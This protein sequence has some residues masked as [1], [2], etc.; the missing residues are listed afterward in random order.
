MKKSSFFLA[1]V[2]V[3]GAPTTSVM[4]ATTD[5]VPQ[6][7]TVQEINYADLLEMNDVDYFVQKIDEYRG[8]HPKANLD[9]INNYLKQEMNDRYSY[10][11][12]PG[13]LYT[14]E[15]PIPID[16]SQLNQQ[17]KDLYNSNMAYGLLSLSTGALAVN[18]AKRRY[19]NDCLDGGNGDA[20]R[21]AFWNAM[22]V[23]QTSVD[24]ATKWA[25][26][27]EEGNPNNNNLDK[28]MDLA[29]NARGRQIG[30]AYPTQ[31][32]GFNTYLAGKVVE[33][34]DTGKL[35]RIS[36]NQLITTDS[37]GKL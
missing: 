4:A 19:T 6:H 10:K 17:E 2:I 23:N 35:V 9:E 24:W 12:N 5:N 20:F 3:L 25:T 16:P 22:M 30:V 13:T 8:K 37:S 33:W 31:T 32:Q 26:A 14:F 7:K 34:I 29:N 15:Y 28:T 1:M 11:I 18:E 21:H 27:H 36:G